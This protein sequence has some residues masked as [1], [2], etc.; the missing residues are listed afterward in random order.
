M[1]ITGAGRGI[2]RAT[3]E[4]FAAKGARLLLAD[5][6]AELLDQTAEEIRAKHG[7]Q[8]WAYEMDVSKKAEVEEMMAFALAHLGGIDV[9]INNRGSAVKRPSWR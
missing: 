4:R 2:G 8:V 5:R 7:T 1:L 6:Q 9:L 3:A